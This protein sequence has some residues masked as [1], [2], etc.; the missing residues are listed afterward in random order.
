LGPERNKSVAAPA[1][2]AIEEVA[3][4]WVLELLGLPLT[5]DVGFVTG[6]T[7]ANFAGLAAARSAVLGRVGWDVNVD[8]LSGAPV[9]HLLVGAER[10]TSRSAISDSAG[11]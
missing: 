5:A 7:M 6:A 10:S 11:R 8:G 1:V 4:R 2:A 3:G 9:V